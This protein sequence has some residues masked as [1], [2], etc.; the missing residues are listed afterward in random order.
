M[1]EPLSSLDLQRRE[2]ILPFIERLRDSINMPILYVSHDLSEITRLADNLILLDAGK[3][4]KSGT[5]E[6]MMS[7]IEI[8]SFFRK[9]NIGSTKEM[10][11]ADH[12]EDGLTKFLMELLIYGYHI[13]N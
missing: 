12:S 13:Q 1:D 4:V 5:V 11:I 7:N 10:T 2:K 6:E 3:I 9:R 8:M